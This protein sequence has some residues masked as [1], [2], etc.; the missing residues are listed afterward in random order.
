MRLFKEYIYPRLILDLITFFV[1][2]MAVGI[3]AARLNI[4]S[5]GVWLGI[6]ANYLMLAFAFI[7]NDVED[8]DDDA[9]Y[10]FEPLHILT[11]LKMNLGLHEQKPGF[12]R[13]QNPFSN[14]MLSKTDGFNLLVS[15][16]VVSVFVS[17]LVGGFYGFLIALTNL[18]IGILYSG[19]VIR[20]KAYM[21][22]DVLSHCYLLAGV[23]VLY[24][25]TY[26]ESRVDLFSYLLL[27]GAMLYSVGGDLWNEYRDFDEDKAAGLKN[28]ASYL[29]KKNT[30][31]ASKILTIGSLLLS[32]SISGYILLSPYIS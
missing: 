31:L 29:G 25:F 32:A 23:Q 17:F 28:T 14:G 11:H 13:F 22:L 26:A 15:I 6:F 27:V 30:N 10:Q 12:R 4:F 19:G 2:L 21:L 16:I 3:I 18:V 24:F 5:F 20:F 7:Y 9:K 8:A 1:P